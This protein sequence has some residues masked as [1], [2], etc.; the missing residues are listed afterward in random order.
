MYFGRD[1]ALAS[2]GLAAHFIPDDVTS[3]V[4]ASIAADSAM[5]R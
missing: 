4:N 5:V 1:F 3:R 2:C